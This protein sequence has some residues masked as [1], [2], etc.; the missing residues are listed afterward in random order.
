MDIKQLHYFVTVV[1]EGTISA[2]A[3]VLHL[4]QPPL[5]CQI[6]L[7]EQELGCSLFERTTRKIRLTEAGCTL[8]ERAN[9]ILNL[10]AA[11]KNEM[12]DYSSGNFGVLRI[13]VVSS[14]CGEF[15]SRELRL[16]SSRHP[17]IRYELYEA[18]TYELLEKTRSG[19]VDFAFVRTPFTAP[20]LDSL[21]LRTEP[22]IAVTAQT[23]EF[24]LPADGVTLQQLADYPLILYRRWEGIL[25][26]AFDEKHLQPNF[27]CVNDSAATALHLACD[28]LGVCIVPASVLSFAAK[29]SVNV[30]SLEHLLLQSDIAVVYR[31]GAYINAGAR[32][33]I[34]QLEAGKEIHS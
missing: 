10:C 28:G 9:A 20:D 21:S 6:K 26:A 27:F 13:G 31:R 14:V 22:M 29:T 18:N 11:A 33:F 23:G 5:S 8:Y 32:A 1:N 25:R 4:S 7:L 24:S 12:T 17:R 16:F 30:C 34:A 19:E 3:K 2:A 15:F